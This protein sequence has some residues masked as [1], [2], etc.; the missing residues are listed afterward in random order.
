MAAAQHKAVVA[1]VRLGAAFGLYAPEAD[2]TDL[3]LSAQGEM[4]GQVPWY[5]G[6]NRNEYFYRCGSEHVAAEETWVITGSRDDD[7]WSRCEGRVWIDLDSARARTD[8]TDRSTAVGGAFFDLSLGQCSEEFAQIRSDSANAESV[9]DGADPN[10]HGRTP[11]IMT[12]PAAGVSSARVACTLVWRLGLFS[13]IGRGGRLLTMLLP[14]G[15]IQ[16]LGHVVVRAGESLTLQSDATSQTSLALGQ[17]QFQVEAGGKLELL[18]VGV[19]DAVGSSA[20]AIFGEVSATNCT[21][22]RCVAGPNLLLR[23][24]EGVS[25]EGSDEQPPVHGVFVASTGGVAGVFLSAA[26]FTASS[27]TFSENRARGAHVSN[28][29][30]AIA[31]LGGTVVLRLGTVMRDNRVD[32]GVMVARGGAINCAYARFDVSDVVFVGNEANGGSDARNVP[33]CSTLRA[34]LVRGGAMDLTNCR[35]TIS[36]SAFRQC[37]AQDALVRATGGALAVGDGSVVEVRNC[38]FDSN[39]AL[40]GAQ[41]TYGGAIRIDANGFVRVANTTFDRNAVMGFAECFGGA[42]TSEGSIALEGGVVFRANV[43]S[44][45]VKAAGGAVAILSPT[46]SLNASGLVFLS[47]TVRHRPCALNHRVLRLLACIYNCSCGT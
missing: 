15:L 23:Y 32:G 7:A 31:T 6:M 35:V 37:K 16:L 1:A 18:G 24:A 8:A 11:E 26:K 45:D 14:A 40:R 30:G 2:V 27:C 9:I 44:G 3:F 38:V 25:L 41:L 29:G 28:S 12:F 5:R 34:Q 21:F 42:I 4:H 10:E 17:W 22:S 39:E 46:A 13:A 36:S 33:G 19:V 20:I 43:V 47:N